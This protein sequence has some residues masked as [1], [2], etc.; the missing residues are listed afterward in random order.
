MENKKH[1]YN[2]Q[3]TVRLSED[4]LNYIDENYEDVAGTADKIAISKF[5]MKAVTSAVTTIKPKTKEVEK[6]VFIDNPE[7]VQQINELKTVNESLS[8]QCENYQKQIP[9]PQSIVL[10]FSPEMKKYVW[11]ILEISKKQKFANSYE[12]L[13]EKIFEILH[14]RGELVLDKEDLKYLETLNNANED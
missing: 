8:A 4:E 10:N 14:K 11:G 9:G 7:L 1:M 2:Y 12:E 6:E 5:F 3:N 13:F